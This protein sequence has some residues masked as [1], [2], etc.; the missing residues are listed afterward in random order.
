MAINEYDYAE[1]EIKSSMTNLHEHGKKGEVNDS[2]LY[3]T[4]PD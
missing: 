3:Q 4:T 2:P 1:E